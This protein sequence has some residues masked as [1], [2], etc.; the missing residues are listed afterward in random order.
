MDAVT[1]SLAQEYVADLKV[2]EGKRGRL[3]LA[4]D[5]NQVLLQHSGR[6]PFSE[7][8]LHDWRMVLET[9]A[10]WLSAL[11]VPYF[12]LVPPNA[13][14]VYPEDLPDNVES[15]PTRP[16]H[17]LIDHL[18][19]H[20]SFAPF[21]YP[22]A[23]MNAAKPAPL[24]PKTDSHWT[25]RGAFVAYRV[26]A[27]Q[28]AALIPMHLVS[29]ADVVFREWTIVG[30]LG[31]KMDPQWQ[32]LDSA[33][34]ISDPRAYLVSDNRVAN[35]GSR[36]ETVCPEAPDSTCLVLGDSFAQKMLRPLAASF[37]RVVMTYLPTLDHALV[38]EVQPDVVVSVLNE[39]FLAKVHFDGGAPSL[40]EVEREKIAAGRLR[41]GPIVALPWLANGAT[42]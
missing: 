2:C 18:A 28:I 38:E 21:I 36:T 20:D 39:R 22:L 19:A 3:F 17:Q 37:R 27:T 25:G 33:A 29:D 8:K 26:L 15:S 41:S 4:N 1:A 11:G 6:A 30:E 34:I 24:Y 10:S 40:H 7:R 13:H 9:R 31:F 42:A 14:S 35:H 16:V 32:S 12:F 5:H 23:E